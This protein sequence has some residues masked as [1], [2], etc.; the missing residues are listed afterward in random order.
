MG[1]VFRMDFRS[2]QREDKELVRLCEPDA[3][4]PA[5]SAEPGSMTILA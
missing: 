1:I 2:C 4:L 3:R 5:S